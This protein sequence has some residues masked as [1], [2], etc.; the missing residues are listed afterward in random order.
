MTYTKKP[1]QLEFSLHNWGKGRGFWGRKQHY[2]E[3]DWVEIVK[4]HVCQTEEFEESVPL[5]IIKQKDDEIIIV[6]GR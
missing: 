6:L 1:S 2:R 3:I 5:E 4:G